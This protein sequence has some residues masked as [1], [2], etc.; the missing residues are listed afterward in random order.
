MPVPFSVCT[1]WTHDRSFPWSESGVFSGRILWSFALQHVS[2]ELWDAKW[3]PFKKK[4]YDSAP[5][6]L[7]GQACAIFEL[8]C[9]SMD[10][11]M[12]HIAMVMNVRM[13]KLVG[14]YYSSQSWT[15][16][17]LDLLV[18]PQSRWCGSRTVFYGS[19]SFS[20]RRALWSVDSWM[21][22]S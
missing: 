1:A 5:Y 3:V 8:L 22:K 12:L 20:I 9:S 6:F 15:N 19:S 7:C 10:Q 18:A 17:S 2:W 4:Y 11:T 16:S 14:L 21:R 13:Q